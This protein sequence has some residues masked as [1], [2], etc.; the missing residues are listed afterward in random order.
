MDAIEFVYENKF[1]T[2]TFGFKLG[3]EEH[4][5]NLKPDEYISEI[6][7]DIVEYAHEGFKK[8]KMTLG[9]LKILTNLQ[10]ISFEH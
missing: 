2:E 8:G 9:N 10:T 6:S 4:I 3:G 7:G 5:Y 1:K